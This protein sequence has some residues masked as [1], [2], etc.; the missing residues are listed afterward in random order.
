M[1]LSCKAL[2][3]TTKAADVFQLL[4]KFSERHQV[5]W[6]KVGSVCMDEASAMIGNKS[7][8]A[9]LE[10]A[11]VPDLI[12][13]HCVLHRHALMAKTLPPHLNKV[14]SVWVQFINFIWGRTLNHRIFNLFCKEIGSEHVVLLFRTEACWLSNPDPYSEASC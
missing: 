7:G 3:T 9:G 13:K 10:K 4:D 5:K 14:L 2:Q 11:R 8:F 6:V 1:S 12:L